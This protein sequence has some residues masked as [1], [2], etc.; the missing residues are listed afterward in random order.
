MN[1]PKTTRN[2]LEQSS[3]HT[4]VC[5]SCIKIGGLN[6]RSKGIFKMSH[7]VNMP[8][9]YST[10]LCPVGPIMRNTFKWANNQ[11]QWMRRLIWFLKPGWLSQHILLLSVKQQPTLTPSIHPSMNPTSGIQPEKHLQH[12]ASKKTNEQPISPSKNPASSVDSA[13]NYSVWRRTGN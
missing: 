4:D 13:V 11:E 5:P 1:T 6:V 9:A 7:P 12:V 8:H 10:V 3:L 2:C